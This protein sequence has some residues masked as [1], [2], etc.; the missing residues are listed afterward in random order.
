MQ[1][2]RYFLGD[3]VKFVTR[4]M[5]ISSRFEAVPLDHRSLIGHLVPSA[6]DMKQL[7]YSAVNQH[8]RED[9]VRSHTRGETSHSP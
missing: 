2:D 3:L 4:Q 5:P 6:Y 1:V 8:I 7:L 9:A